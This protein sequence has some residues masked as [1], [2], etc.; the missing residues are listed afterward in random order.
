MRIISQ[1]G[2]TDYPYENSVVYVVKN[3]ILIRCNGE[4]DIVATYNTEEK[5]TAIIELLRYVYGG[6]EYCFKS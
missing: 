3:K 1:D 4:D 2:T 6:V 5:A